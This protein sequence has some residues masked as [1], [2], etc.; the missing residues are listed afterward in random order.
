MSLMGYGKMA[1]VGATVATGTAIGGTLLATG[2]TMKAGKSIGSDALSKIGLS[3]GSYGS[4]D[5][6]NGQTPT[7]IQKLAKAM[8]TK[9]YMTG[10]N[11]KKNTSKDGKI[12][13]SDI[14]INAGANSLDNAVRKVIPRASY[15]SSYYRRRKN[16]N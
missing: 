9:M 8:G 15:N 5:S 14:F 16:M 3:L 7:Q 2:G 12:S 11:M 1:G 6:S 4:I 13:T 10:Q